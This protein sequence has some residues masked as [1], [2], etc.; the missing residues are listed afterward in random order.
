MKPAE[1]R[2][3]WLV[4]LL[5]HLACGGYYAFVAL[6]YHTIPTTLVG[7]H[8]KANQLMM[9]M[10]HVPVLVGTN[11]V[12]SALHAA[13]LCEMVVKSMSRRALFFHS[14][15]FK[16]SAAFAKVRSLIE[17]VVSNHRVLD[18]VVAVTTNSLR[19]IETTAPNA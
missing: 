5:I 9:E 12:F 15:A 3:L 10:R 17:V 13:F 11:A 2:I 8:M 7:E 6:L 4:I 16:L 1:T 19:H 14:R 18:S